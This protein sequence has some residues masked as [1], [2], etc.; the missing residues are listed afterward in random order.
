MPFYT[1]LV[2]VK[3]S[4]MFIKD[5]SRTGNS[6]LVVGDSIS[7]ILNKSTQGFAII[8]VLQEFQKHML[9]RKWCKF[10]NDHIKLPK[11]SMSILLCLFV[12]SV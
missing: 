10:C 3:P 8:N 2:A 5:H 6:Y 1:L 12:V 11:S 7:Q 4:W 9:F